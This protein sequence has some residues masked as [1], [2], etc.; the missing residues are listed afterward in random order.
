MPPQEGQQ[1]AVLRYFGVLMESQKLNKAESIE[2][3]R[4]ALMQGKVQLIERWLTEDKITCSE[5]L[6]DM[7]MQAGRASAAAGC[8][9]AGKGGCVCACGTEPRHR[10]HV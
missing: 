3:A 4:P 2:L 6:G 10:R 7:V 1:P 8:G 9:H 5:A